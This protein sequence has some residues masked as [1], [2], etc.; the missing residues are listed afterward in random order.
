MQLRDVLARGRRLL[1]FLVPLFVF[2]ALVVVGR[3][4]SP[5]S[6]ADDAFAAAPEV[7][8]S[9]SAEAGAAPADSSSAAAGAADASSS[10]D[11]SRPALEE[12]ADGA[13]IVDLNVADED[14]LRRLPGIGPTRARAILALRAKLGRFKSVDDLA[15]IKGIGRSLLRRLRPWVRTT[16]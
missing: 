13:V 14:D 10:T 3:R 9:P 1:A 6:T 8:S 15:R 5:P 4:M 2:V 7:A 16:T 11:A 12:L